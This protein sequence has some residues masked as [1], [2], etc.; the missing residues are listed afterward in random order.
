MPKLSVILPC[1]NVAKYFSRVSKSLL[2]QTFEDFEVFFIN[3]GSQDEIHQVF[4]QLSLDDRFHLIDQENSGS[5]AA[6]NHGLT[7]AKGEYIYFLDPDDFIYE[8]LFEEVTSQLDA[9]RSD[10]AVFGFDVYDISSKRSSRRVPTYKRNYQT[11]KEVREALPGL[12]F[13]TSISAVWNKMYRRS[14]LLE[15][16]LISSTL[17]VGQDAEFNWRVWDKVQ[18][19]LILDKAY[20]QYQVNRKG[21]VRTDYHQKQFPSELIILERMIEI[22]QGWHNA[23]DFLPLLSNYRI[24]IAFGE[25]LNRRKIK[26]KSDQ[27]VTP[28]L[29]ELVANVRYQEVRG[30]DKYYKLFLLK[31]WH[32]LELLARLIK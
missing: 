30:K 10:L 6:R 7:L 22:T 28:E 1:Y 16:H 4:Q 32:L 24:D 26:K 18:N 2:N 19:L 9:S 15:H 29:R 11:K 17:P 12:S 20:H 27:I 13:E 3:D 23:E 31:H 14:F 25:V 21:S 8:N 5:G